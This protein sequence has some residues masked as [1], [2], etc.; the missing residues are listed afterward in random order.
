MKAKDYSKRLKSN[1]CDEEMGQIALDFL[2]EIFTLIDSRHAKTDEAVCSVFDE[3]DN[4]WRVF[5]RDFDGIVK[6]D[7][8]EI[9][10]KMKMPDLHKAWMIVK[11]NGGRMPP[12]R[13]TP[14]EAGY[15]DLDKFWNNLFWG[16]K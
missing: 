4:K 11:A 6:P 14:P 3:L 5:A 1:L 8:F 9:L 16:E 12:A 13:I 15:V 7:G 2:T 10:V